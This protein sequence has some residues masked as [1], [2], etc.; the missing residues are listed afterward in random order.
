MSS[1]RIFVRAVRVL[2]AALSLGIG[3][4][5]T[6]ATV[7]VMTYNT[8]HGGTKA[9]PPT[10]DAE[11]DTIA[12]QNPDVVV[13]Q[14]ANASQ[15]SYY[16]DGLNARLGTS[17]W[18]GMSAKHCKSGTQPIC[19]YQPGESVMI[20]TR[21]TTLATNSTLIWANNDYWVAGPTIRM[22]V[23]LG[24]GTPL[25][26]FV[27]HTPALSGWGASRVKYVTAF[28][29]WAQNF[30]GPQF[31]GGDFNER[32]TGASIADMEQMY[33]DAW[34]TLGSGPGYTHPADTPTSRIDYWFSNGGS[35]LASVAVVPDAVDSDHRPVVAIYGVAPTT[36]TPPPAAQETTL[37]HD[38][39]ATFDATKWVKRLFTGT[40][41]STIGLTSS[42][43]LQIGP[44]KSS[45]TG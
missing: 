15:L 37:L 31:V 2:A 38:S 3:V 7:K 22:Q 25:N 39:L 40:Q 18:H 21:L 44:L 13:L 24:D 8:N 9:T 29:R 41:D 6:A 42:G 12:A 28:Q 4:P 20:L 19:T 43:A 23:A 11:I 32:P 16:V 10:T 14:E 27:C 36:V 5:A 30:P 35:T 17:A 45:T 26:V 34:A 33:A 1:R